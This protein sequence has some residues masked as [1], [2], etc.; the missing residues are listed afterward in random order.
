MQSSMEMRCANARNTFLE[1]QRAL[2]A[3]PSARAR[4]SRELLSLLNN[5]LF[6]VPYEEGEPEIQAAH[7][8]L[9]VYGYE[10]TQPEADDGEDK[11]FYQ[12]WKGTVWT[13]VNKLFDTTAAPASSS[14]QD[15]V[16]DLDTPQDPELEK[17]RE[18]YEKMIEEEQQRNQLEEEAL[19]QA[20]GEM[21]AAAARSWDD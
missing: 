20:A 6:A 3:V 9:V 5:R 16:V 12:K 7:S 8:V 13:T 10:E 14:E 2:D 1:M 15:A 4:Q 17:I 21:E 11:D 19:L 18:E